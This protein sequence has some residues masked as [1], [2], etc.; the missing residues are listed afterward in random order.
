MI[1]AFAADLLTCQTHEVGLRLFLDIAAYFAID[2]NQRNPG[3]VLLQLPRLLGDL[4]YV[5]ISVLCDAFVYHGPAYTAC[6]RA[7]FGSTVGDLVVG[8]AGYNLDGLQGL[9]GHLRHAR[10]DFV[11]FAFGVPMLADDSVCGGPVDGSSVL[12]QPGLSERQQGYVKT[13]L[14]LLVRRKQLTFDEFLAVRA[15]ALVDDC[16]EHFLHVDAE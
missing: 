1:S 14:E 4:E 7:F 16:D 10:L 11:A 3:D 6:L 12:V 5:V 8:H 13:V 9:L 2:R 15:E